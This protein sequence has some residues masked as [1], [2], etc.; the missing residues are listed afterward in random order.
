MAKKLKGELVAAQL[1]W[2]AD[3]IEG[4]ENIDGQRIGWDGGTHAF[5]KALDSVEKTLD[6]NIA[7]VEARRAER[8]KLISAGQQQKF[9]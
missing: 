6:D 9:V 5:L 2:I 1:R 8:R 7:S 3:K 4:Y